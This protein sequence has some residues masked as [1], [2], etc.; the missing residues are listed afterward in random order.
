M[1]TFFDD[2]PFARTVAGALLFLAAGAFAA[3]VFWQLA[4]DASLW[5]FGREV[6]AQ[7]VDRW[8]EP[9]GEL[10]EG[11]VDF[12]YYLQYRFTTDRGQTITRTITV[13]PGEWGEAEDTVSVVYFPPISEHN[14][15]DQSRYI[16]LLACAY[17]P[18]TMIGLGALFVG[19]RLLRQGAS[20]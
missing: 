18:L 1:W 6:Q 5:F 19:W 10:G 13:G 16:P 17:L 14:Q 9:I 3:L 4:R 8:V 7:V 12:Y 15:L 11:E 2:H 20:A